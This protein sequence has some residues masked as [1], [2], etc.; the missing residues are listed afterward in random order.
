M[1]KFTDTLNNHQL[2]QDR[3]S[4][5][6]EFLCEVRG[7][8]NEMPCGKLRDVCVFAAGSLGRFEAGRRSDLDVFFLAH[9]DSRGELARSVTRL[10]EIEVFA[11]LIKLNEK[12]HLPAFSGDGQYLRVHEVDDLINATGDSSRDDNENLFTARL[13]LLLESKPLSN[14]S[15][16]EASI[17]RVVDNYFRD[18]KGRKDFRPLFLLND[19]L[20][21]W[22]T[23]CLNY[24]RTR[25]LQKPWWKTNLN[26]KFSRKLTVFST[27][28]AIVSER[29]KTTDDFVSFAREI[30]LKRLAETLD[31]IG[32]ES[33]HPLFGTLLD[34]Y[35]S[36]LAAK[37][38]SEVGADPSQRT[39]IFSQK[40]EL[41]S[42]F[43]CEA[44]RSDRLKRDLVKYVLI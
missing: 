42:E 22:R 43:F 29:I 1:K 31:Y 16:Y 6:K 8:L 17:R 15:L 9:S 44:L 11:D 30:P 41:F 23:L 5:S 3:F 13:L 19:V 35:E 37:S 27:V 33:L 34:D 38:H 4:H 40:A 32:D 18:G 2:L 21:Y 39:R 25:T 14:D 36:F 20:R 7:V 12:L 10:Q 26:L 24:E 28:L